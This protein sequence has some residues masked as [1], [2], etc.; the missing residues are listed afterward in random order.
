MNSYLLGSQQ[1]QCGGSAFIIVKNRV[2]G[3]MFKGLFAFSDPRA[4]KYTKNTYPSLHSS[5]VSAALEGNSLF[6]YGPPQ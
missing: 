2:L 6:Q 3:F 4:S 5:S 1:L